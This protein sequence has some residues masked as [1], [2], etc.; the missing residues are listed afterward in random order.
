MP[1]NSSKKIERLIYFTMLATYVYDGLFSPKFCCTLTVDYV[2]ICKSLQQLGNIK[3][4]KKVHYAVT[5]INF[6]LHYGS[7]LYGEQLQTRLDKS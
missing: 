2:I 4:Q 3:F 6:I 1:I 5:E 7:N